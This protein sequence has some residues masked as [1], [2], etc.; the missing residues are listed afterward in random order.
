MRAVALALLVVS[1]TTAPAVPADAKSLGPRVVRDA[2]AGRHTL[3]A[4]GQ[5][6][7]DTATEASISVNPHNPRNAVTVFQAGRVDAGCA[8][9]LGYATTFNGG[10]TWSYGAF[11]KLTVANGGTYPLASD[12]VVAFGPGNVVYANHLM[13][14]ETGNDLAI[15]VSTNGGKTWGNPITVPTERTLPL[16]DKNWITVDTQSGP[17]HH[18]GRLYL[19]WD[20]VA[21][22]VAMYSD[23]LAKTWNGPFVV[24]PGQGIGVVPLVMPNG[25]LTVVFNGF[26]PVPAVLAGTSDPGDLAGPSKFMVVTAPSAGSVPTGGPLV[27]TPPTT[28]ATYRGTDVRVHRAGEDLPTAAADPKTGRLYAGWSDNRFRTDEVNDVVITHSDDGGITWSP[29]TRVNRG[30]SDDYVEHFTPA[31]AVGNDGIV[32]IAYRQQRQAVQ[33]SDIPL[34]TPFVDTVYQQST[35]GVSFTKPLK[36]NRRVRTDMRFACFSRESAFLGDYAGVAVHGSWAY[37]V[38]PEAYRLNKR[39][40]A[41]WPPAVHHQ[42]IWV[43]VVD[44]DGNGRP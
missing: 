38:H 28:V 33:A 18:P 37:V 36:V 7:Q 4:E 10:K 39:E 21:P 25:D 8:Q 11:P 44:S 19:V 23:D 32:R 31:M 26:Y 24:Y 13:C 6:Q 3:E 2:E 40:P 41:D 27:F 16:D 34:D 22:V 12:P 5:Q 30:P 1:L 29:V 35:D 17:G 15:S 14:E 20:N 42:R 43:G 9:T